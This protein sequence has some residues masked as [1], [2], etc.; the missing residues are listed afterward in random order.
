M[1]YD[2][3][4]KTQREK[5]RTS[6]MTTGH[7]NEFLNFLKGFGE[8]AYNHEIKITQED[9]ETR[10]PFPK[11]CAECLIKCYKFVDEI[12]KA[13]EE[14]SE[15]YKNFDKELQYAWTLLW[16]RY[17]KWREKG[18]TKNC[19]MDTSREICI[20]ASEKNCIWSGIKNQCTYSSRRGHTYSHDFF[21]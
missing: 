4:Y 1:S 7:L 20:H 14:K 17:I 6:N 15:T 18:F 21:N 13:A 10:C 2:S 9:I 12:K 5:F 8:A 11:P 16:G 19:P 3:K